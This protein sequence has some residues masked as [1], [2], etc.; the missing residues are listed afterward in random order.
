MNQQR[1]P[2]M[3]ESDAAYLKKYFQKNL[4]KPVIL[5]LTDNAT[6]M[7]SVRRKHDAISLRLHHIF[8][9]ADE[10]VLD[11]VTQ[12]IKGKEGRTP[13]IKAF[14]RNN[15]SYLVIRNSAVKKLFVIDHI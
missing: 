14:I 2:F 12:F 3:L 5:I 10:R 1:L 11:E 6:S 9:N 13:A 4:D 7:I 8:L 15:K